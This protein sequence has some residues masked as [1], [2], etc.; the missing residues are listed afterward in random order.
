MRVGDEKDEDEADTVGASTLRVE[1]VKFNPDNIEFDFLGK[2]SV[3][4]EKKIKIS[5]ADPAFIKNMKEFTQNKNR[6]DL[7][8]HGIDSR[9]VNQFFGKC[10]NGLTAKVFRT[11]HATKT[12]VSYLRNVKT[13]PNDGYQSRLYQAK[14]GNLELR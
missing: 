12:L 11:Y 14:M 8:F 1:H 9:H 4:W 7:V 6:T 3:R 13:Q 2:D 10:I 5:D